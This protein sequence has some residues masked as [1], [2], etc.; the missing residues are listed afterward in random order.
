MALATLE[1]LGSFAVLTAL[2]AVI[3]V[4]AAAQSPPD[5]GSVRQQIEQQQRP[6]LPPRKAAPAPVAEAASA[7]AGPAGITLTV[8]SFRFS[9][10]TL[11][12][13]SR[14]AQAV[15]AYRGRPID[16]SQLQAAAQAVGAAY[17]DAGWIARAYLPRQDI[18]DGLVS[19]RVVEARQ[20]RV[21]VE[22]GE[23]K[24]VRTDLIVGEFDQAQHRGYAISSAA[25]DRALL[26]ADDLPGVQV[27]GSLRAGTR[28]Q[29][30][31]IVLA[32][33][34]DPL[35]AG[36]VALDNSGERSTGAAR[37]AVNFDLQSPLRLGDQFAGH[38]VH[39]QGTDALRFAYS[40]PLGFDGWRSG[41]HGSV[42]HY[43][44]ILPA[45][46]ALAAKG[47]STGVGIDASWPLWRSRLRNL[48]LSA[49][50]DH[51]GF[52]N[53]SAGAVTTRYHIDSISVGA[54]YNAADDLGG[55]IF[56]AG[57]NRA[58]VQL[59]AGRRSAEVGV[60]DQNYAKLRWS[61]SRQQAFFTD[62]TL[63]ASLAG[64]F[65]AQVLDSSERFYLGGASAVR[66][67]P[68]SEAG[69]ANGELI[70]IELRRRL[71]AGFSVGAFYDLGHVRPD[72]IGGDWVLRG[73]GLA[74][75]WAGA[76]GASV[77][78]SWSRRI[79]RNPNPTASGSDQ[80]GSLV[81][82]RFWLSSDLRF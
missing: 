74:L 63:Q 62:W 31:D 30:A 21:L 78:A 12:S 15:A 66:A 41:V 46:A 49:A 80:D 72:G 44:L 11:L 20:G 57:F 25:L 45:F 54:D 8:K 34:D 59:A 52:N 40:V 51:N 6:A 39:S 38:A 48:Y 65:S 36:D 58:A 5:A 17:R 2:I 18:V 29:E 22:G 33:T 53:L 73:A 27:A 79:G 81:A 82:N 47:D 4:G 64:Q 43:R 42:I 76:Q 35:L 37:L 75:S 32:L 61:A 19:I 55:D 9:G 23:S 77:Q 7:P 56:G 16:F 67:Y 14:L 60:A 24:R 3:S 50:I 70:Q 68:A 71:P 13:D 26:L 28:E 1:R 10:N 69:A